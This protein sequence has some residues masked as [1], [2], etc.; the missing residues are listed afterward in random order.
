M[1]P[2]EL[3][4]K[5][6]IAHKNVKHINEFGF[7]SFTGYN[8]PRSHNLVLRRIAKNYVFFRNHVIC[9]DPVSSGLTGSNPVR[10]V[11]FS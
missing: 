10:G 4:S 5:I 3:Y 6:L 2:E 9:K 1:I 8:M 11:F 7:S